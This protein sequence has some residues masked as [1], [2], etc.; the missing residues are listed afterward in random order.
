MIRAALVLLLVVGFAEIAASGHPTA[1]VRAQATPDPDEHL[2]VGTWIVEDLHPQDGGPPL[3]IA[4]ATV[5]AD[6]NMLLNST[7]VGQGAMQGEWSAADD[8]GATVTVVN[9]G[10]DQSGA[11]DGTL[12]RTRGKIEV[13]AGGE[14]WLGGFTYELIH[15]DGEVGFTFYSG[16][17]GTRV[18]IEPTD[19]VA[20]TLLPAT[21]AA[22]PAARTGSV[23]IR[24]FGC[25]AEL[26]TQ[27]AGEG[28][29]GQAELLAACTP[30]ASPEVAPTLYTLPDGEPTAGMVTAPGVYR[31]EG[32]AL[33]DYAVGGN[34]EMPADLA[35][36]LLTDANGDVLQNPALRLD[37]TSPHVEYRDF[38]F[39]AEATPAAGLP[40]TPDSG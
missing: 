6:G 31:W 21:P 7:G 1:G 23:T 4:M 12:Q 16:W 40:P 24:V 13:D 25:P 3:T 29:L 19:P 11:S 2:L 14:T 15:P 22:T 18:A 26:M 38:Y 20:M 8:R 27:P 17:R 32:L 36:L 35:G 34:G 37:P 5:F 28:E 9:V 30:L 33:G 39:R 10:T